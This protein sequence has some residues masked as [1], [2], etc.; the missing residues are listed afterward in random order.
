MR[1]VLVA[2][3]AV[4]FMLAVAASGA[5]SFEVRK[6]SETATTI[7]LGWDA[8]PGADGY[9]FY[10]DGVAVSRTFDPARVT[11]KYAKG[12]AV[13]K[14]E[15]LHV[16]AGNTGSYPPPVTPPP[17]PGNVL[18]LS[19]TM[20]A[21]VFQQKVAAAAA[22]SLTVRPAGGQ[23]SF[24]VT[25]EVSF[26]RANV[27]IQHADLDEILIEA[28]ADNVTIEDSFLN[29]FYLRSGGVDR[30]TLQ[31]STIDGEYRNNQNWMYDATNFRFLG[32][33]FRRFD[34]Q[35]D[36]NNHSEAIFV[37]AGN[38]NGLIEGNM[39]DNNGRTG[40]LFFSWWGGSETDSST[41]PRDICVRGNTFTNTHG[42]YDIQ[43]RQEFP[44]SWPLFI[45][46][47]P[48][49]TWSAVNGGSSFPTRACHA[50]FG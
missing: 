10:A 41:W 31:R 34:D 18:E 6:V 3:A 8:Q 11:V 39:F 28:S 16:A 25:G 48:S 12:P 40:H 49:N 14:V 2:A 26:T 43:Y 21:T 7:T 27:T 42:A 38:R 32:N 35:S 46:P 33:T 36:P 29:F 9:R 20:S 15:V 17:P 37:A 1:H 50:S 13:F 44:S 19:G 30:F 5:S 47:P 24:K 22:G 45:E 23:S 4:F